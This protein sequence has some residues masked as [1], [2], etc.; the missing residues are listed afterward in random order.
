VAGWLR[1][2]KG[3]GGQALYLVDGQRDQPGVG[4]RPVS[5]AGRRRSLGIGAFSQLGGSDR[6][7]REGG[8]DQH[9][10]PQDGDV[11]PGLALVEAEAGFPDLEA[12]LNRPPLI[13][14]KRKSS[15]VWGPVS[16][17]Y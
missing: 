10:V 7:D 14:V 3:G 6:A 16:G 2:A 12:L 17:R 13:P 5:R 8:H 9:E 11:E 4:G 1:V 15:L